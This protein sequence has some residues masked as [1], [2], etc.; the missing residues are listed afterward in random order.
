MNIQR[1]NA[2]CNTCTLKLVTI[3]YRRAPWFRLLREP[4]KLGMRTLSRI[5][6]VNVNEYVVRTP[7]CYNCIRFYKTALREKSA[8]FRWLHRW[9]NPMFDYF[10]ENIVTKEE[11][12]QSKSYAKAASSSGLK[13]EETDDWMRGM[14]TGF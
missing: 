13:P 9:M 10:L 7:A 8:T 14:K 11:L 12:S 1:K 6:H 2:V 3:A 5:H 4:L